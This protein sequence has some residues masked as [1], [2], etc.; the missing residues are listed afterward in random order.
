MPSGPGLTLMRCT[1]SPRVT[2]MIGSAGTKCDGVSTC[3][4]SGS[5][6]PQN[7]HAVSSRR[8]AD[9]SCQRARHLRWTSRGHAHG[10]LRSP[11]SRQM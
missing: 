8:P 2:T 9:C 5:S 4:Q 11:P 7:R 3:F 1:W 10:R 6:E